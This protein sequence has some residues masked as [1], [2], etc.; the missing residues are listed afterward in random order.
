MTVVLLKAS[1]TIYSCIS[2]Y[3]QMAVLPPAEC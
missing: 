2:I 1:S 3:W